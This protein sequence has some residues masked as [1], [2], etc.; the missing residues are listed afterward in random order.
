MV[1]KNIKKPTEV[2]VATKLLYLTLI[3]SI[4]ATLI[5]PE[6]EVL[7]E[8]IPKSEHHGILLSFWI[9]MIIMY[10]IYFYIIYSI[11]AGRHWARVLYVSLFFIWFIL[12][13]IGLDHLLNHPLHLI[14]PLVQMI[15]NITAIFLLFQTHVNYWFEQD[16]NKS[17]FENTK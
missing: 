16:I 3:I 5:V 10:F 4:V 12:F 13:L 8:K 15:I 2:F 17:Q 7:L 14:L 11:N 6:T 1:A 9:A